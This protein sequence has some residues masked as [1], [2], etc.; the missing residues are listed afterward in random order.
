MKGIQKESKA[1]ENKLQQM[2]GNEIGIM[3]VMK[4]NEQM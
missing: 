3:I 4:G 2:K 1:N